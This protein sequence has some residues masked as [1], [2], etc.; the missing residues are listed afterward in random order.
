MIYPIFKNNRHSDFTDLVRVQE[1]DTTTIE[2]FLIMLGQNNEWL[3]PFAKEVS[4]LKI[5]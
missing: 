1:S 4:E 5:V 3:A 2:D